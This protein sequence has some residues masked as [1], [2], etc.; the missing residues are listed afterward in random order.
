MNHPVDRLI[1]FSRYM[2]SE[3]KYEEEETFLQTVI[4]QG[5]E[6]DDLRDELYVICKSVNR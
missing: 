5:L 3:M 1:L 4:S 6:R 2:K